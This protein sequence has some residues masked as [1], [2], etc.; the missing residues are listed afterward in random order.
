MDL[1]RTTFLE[2]GIGELVLIMLWWL[3]SFD[4]GH[5]YKGKIVAHDT[6]DFL[7]CCEDMALDGDSLLH[8]AVHD[9]LGRRRSFTCGEGKS[10][11]AFNNMST[12]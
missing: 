3:M 11:H 12:S 2:K 1:S 6:H 5:L 9:S 8:G 4:E 10:M 7:L